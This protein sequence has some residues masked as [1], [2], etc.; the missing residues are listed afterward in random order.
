MKLYKNITRLHQHGGLTSCRKPISEIASVPF[1]V[2][3][4]VDDHVECKMQILKCNIVCLVDSFVKFV[5]VAMVVLKG[6][7]I[8]GSGCLDIR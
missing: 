5:T 2:V 3:T 7:C 1:F 6:F 8:K 4:K